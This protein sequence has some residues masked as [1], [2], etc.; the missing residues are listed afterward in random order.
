MSAE[1]TRK[2]KHSVSSLLERL[3]AALRWIGLE[4]GR[5]A[6]YK[7]LVA[8]YSEGQRS[9]DHFFSY[10]QSMEVLIIYDAWEQEAINFPGLKEKISYVLKKGAILS[11]DE[12]IS[13]NRPRNDGFVYILAG[14]LLHGSK[15]QI[16]SLD[17]CRNSGL[18][19]VLPGKLFRNDIV[20]LVE[21]EPIAIECKRPMSLTTLGENVGKA[22]QQISYGEN[23]SG[24]IAVDVTKLIEQPGQYLDASTLDRGADYLT[25]EVEKILVPVAAQ[26]PQP[27]LLGFI[28]YASVPLISNVQS[29]ILDSQGKP[30]ENEGFRTAG[31]AW[32]SIRNK[33]SPRGVL[34][35]E[36]QRGFLRSRHDVPKDAVPIR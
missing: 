17:G 24:I 14:K 28:G 11:E 16:V 3:D 18:S 19:T 12:T 30:F 8:E 27:T 22:F 4:H 2:W 29:V 6:T 31:V 33:K 25:D 34:V 32:V 5:A 23:P 7:K 35:H 13:S 9:N 20:I 26:Y 1:D 15:V 36:L 10:H 21:G